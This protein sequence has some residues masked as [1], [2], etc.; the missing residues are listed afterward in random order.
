[1][2][3]QVGVIN[4]ALSKIGD[5][6]ITAITDSSKQAIYANIHWENARDTVLEEYPWNFAIKRSGTTLNSYATWGYDHKYTLPSDCLRVLEAVAGTTPT[7]TT[8]AGSSAANLDYTNTIDY[9]IEG[10]S[11]SSTYLVTSEDAPIYI[12]YISKVTDVAAW[13]P[14][15]AEAVACKLAHLLCES[16]SASPTSHRGLL[17]DE[18]ETAINRAKGID[19]D[20]GRDTI[21]GYYEMTY[22][23]DN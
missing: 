23:R 11:G 10:G 8:I 17:N 19:F 3:T 13:P 15:F 2:A 20:E 22:C 7:T 9:R 14:T 21:R 1:M 5:Y 12:K 4:I 6:Y 18:Y 16:L